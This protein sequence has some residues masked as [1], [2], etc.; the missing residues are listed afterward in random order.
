MNQAEFST[1]ASGLKNESFPT[2]RTVV[3]LFLGALPAVPA[4]AS[5]VKI[6]SLSSRERPRVPRTTV[7]PPPPVPELF[8]VELKKDPSLTSEAY[9]NLLATKLRT[10][11]TLQAYFNQRMKY[12][13]EDRDHWQPATETIGRVADGKMLGDCDDYAFLA[14]EIVRRQGHNAHVV[15]LPSHAECMWI[16]KRPDGRF[17]GHSMGTFNYDCNG[18]RIYYRFRVDRE[19]A[20]GYPS[21]GEA[22][23]SL[24]LKYRE[25]PINELRAK[26]K[27]EQLRDFTLNPQAV[28]VM[29]VKNFASFFFVS[30]TEP[31][32]H[33]THVC[34]ADY[35][36]PTGPV[37]YTPPYSQPI[38]GLKGGETN[39]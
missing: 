4:V 20:K 29:E 22:L 24:C 25:C 26:K 32:L 28:T 37:A 36:A 38:P 15:Y 33:E 18:N 10:P 7:P 39:P 30:K 3:K 11:E 9:L 14:R 17:D 19:R 23:Q 35:F 27:K 2:R 8:S 13:S 12:V 34:N 16:T 21:I 5:V 6:F 31:V 1:H